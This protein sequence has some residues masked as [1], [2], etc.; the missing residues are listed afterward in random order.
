MPLV[1]PACAK[2]IEDHLRTYGIV[3]DW[4][5]SSDG[6][7]P[8]QDPWVDDVL[9]NVRFK[10]WQRVEKIHELVNGNDKALQHYLR[11]MASTS[12]VSWLR[13]NRFVP[14]NVKRDG[15]RRRTVNGKRICYSFKNCVCKACQ[16]EGSCWVRPL[17][18]ETDKT[19]LSL[20]RDSEAIGSLYGGIA[21][22]NGSPVPTEFL[23]LP[24]GALDAV[25]KVPGYDLLI[26]FYADVPDQ[27]LA[28]ARG[29]TTGA[30]RHG[31]DGL[32]WPH[33]TA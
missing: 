9:Q 27:D 22:L 14:T 23:R 20:D 1:I 32:I 29:V 15:C 25:R 17:Q 19:P 7:P 10:A 30:I 2:E 21:A 31:N 33:A 18:H 5:R 26:D 3:S 28:A 12:A 4:V 24:Y 8:H 16:Q 13:S 11:T 6:M